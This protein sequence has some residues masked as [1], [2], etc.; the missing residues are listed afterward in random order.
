MN[1]LKHPCIFLDVWN[2]IG[3]HTK[4]T[5]SEIRFVLTSWYGEISH[6]LQGFSTIPVLKK[7][8]PIPPCPS[9]KNLPVAKNRRL[10]D[11]SVWGGGCWRRLREIRCPNGKRKNDPRNGDKWIQM[12]Q[13]NLFVGTYFFKKML[14]AFDVGGY[15]DCS[16]VCLFVLKNNLGPVL[17]TP[18]LKW[19]RQ[20][21][22]NVIFEPER[23]WFAWVTLES[24][25]IF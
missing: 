7:I 13:P 11:G 6:D 16:R 18:W 5:N 8:P 9:L 10:L 14:V 25:M 15:T 19:T 17:Q 1:E 24:K 4:K 20:E 2:S 23:P 22:E 3:R 21:K 12:S